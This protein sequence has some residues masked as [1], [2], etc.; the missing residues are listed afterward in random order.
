MLTNSL[1]YPLPCMS[2]RCA[3]WIP[4]TWSSYSPESQP[5]LII[6]PPSLYLGRN[7]AAPREHCLLDHLLKGYF[8]SFIHTGRIIIFLVHLLYFKM[9][10]FYFLTK[11]KRK[12]RKKER[13][14]CLPVTTIRDSRLCF[15][16][17]A[18]FLVLS[19]NFD[20]DPHWFN[21]NFNYQTGS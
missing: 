20:K 6:S 3:L 11:K 4:K 17:S 16:S 2:F 18:D 8:I 10:T 21:V 7:V 15:S 12:E 14:P 13:N 19:L 1:L 9:L 5:H